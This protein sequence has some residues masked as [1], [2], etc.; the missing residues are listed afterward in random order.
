MYTEN[1]CHTAPLTTLET[2]H[3]TLLKSQ[4]GMKE[5]L[6]KRAASLLQAFRNANTLSTSSSHEL[7]GIA[8]PLAPFSS[9]NVYDMRDKRATTSL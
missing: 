3:H 8:L 6:R 5:A 7:A 4:M 1:L 2:K 9:R